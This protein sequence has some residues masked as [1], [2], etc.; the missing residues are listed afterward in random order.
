MSQL[1]VAGRVDIGGG[2]LE[3]INPKENVEKASAM[4]KIGKISYELMTINKNY[5]TISPRVVHIGR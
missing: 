5:S 2:Q 4:Q 3:V 1:N